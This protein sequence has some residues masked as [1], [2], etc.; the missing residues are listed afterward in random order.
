[1]DNCSLFNRPRQQ[2]DR[3]G[4]LGRLRAPSLL[5]CHSQGASLPSLPAAFDD[6]SASSG[7]VAM[8]TILK[9]ACFAFHISN[10]WWVLNGSPTGYEVMGVT[11]AARHTGPVACWVR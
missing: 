4:A 2:F 1:M 6:R 7:F 9:T 8:M 3:E 11:A 10:S 5:I